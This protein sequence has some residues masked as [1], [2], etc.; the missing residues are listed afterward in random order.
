MD[1]LYR[2]FLV[3]YLKRLQL[4]HSKKITTRAPMFSDIFVVVYFI[5]FFESKKERQAIYS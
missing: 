5:Y 4:I 2:F 3:V 1:V